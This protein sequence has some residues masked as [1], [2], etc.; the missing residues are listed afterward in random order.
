MIE[1]KRG[2]AAAGLLA[3]IAMAAN[4]NADPPP[5]KS[6][7][8][9]GQGAGKAAAKGLDAKP[10]KG[11][12]AVPGD[13]GLPGDKG[14]PGDKGAL[15]DKGPP[16]D[17][18]QPGAEGASPHGKHG[19][20]PHSELRE[21]RDQLKAGK[22]KKAD[23]EASL[24]KLQE[25]NKERRDNHR[26]ALKARW[27]EHLA[28]ADTQNELSVHE[29]RMAKL[30]RL[31]LL[32]QSERTGNDAEKL[33]ERIEKLIDLENARHEK[34]MTQITSKAAVPAPAQS[35]AVNTEVTK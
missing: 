31:L 23:L 16:G 10:D 25:T 34:R 13:K 4:A 29:R 14:Q 21:L 8:A 7:S 20:R 32:A 30:N 11:P 5:G 28:K 18:G 17:K 6:E 12:S 1:L 15:S 22:L 26:A 35:A 33:T 2:L 27:G 19:G 9:P 24:K 3:T